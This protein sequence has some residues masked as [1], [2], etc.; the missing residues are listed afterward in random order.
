MASSLVIHIAAGEDKHT[1]VLSQDRIRIGASEDCELRLQASS[2]PA[3]PRADGIL[4]EL[5]RTNGHYRIKDFDQ[6]LDLT[7]NGKPLAVNA[8]IKDGDEVRCEPASLALSFFPV[9][10]LPALIGHRQQTQVA[11]FIETA[12]M[13]SAATAR[14]D[15]AKVFLREFT[16]EL[17][18]EIKP[19]TKIITLAIALALVGGI[20]YLGFGLYNELKRS[21][22]A[23]GGLRE[24]LA[25][26]QKQIADTKKLLGDLDKSNQNIL[27]SLSLAPKLRTDYGGGVCMILGSYDFIEKSTG[28]PLRYPEVQTNEDGTVIQNGDETMQLTPEGNGAIAEFQAV[29]SGFHV[30]DGYVLT[31]RHVAHPWLAD[32]RA[33]ILTSSVRGTPRLK[34]LLA[35]FPDHAQ[36]ITLKFKMAAQRDDLAVCTF[37]PGEAPNNLPALPLDQDSDAV[38]VGKTVVLMGYPN[39]PDRLLALRDD[40]E[41]YLIRARCGGSLGTLLN[42][43]SEKNRIQPLTTQGNITDLDVHRVVYDARTAEG[44]SGAPLFGQSGRVIGVNFAIFTENTASNFAVPI[45]YA[46]TLLER[47]GWKSPDATEEANENTDADSNQTSP[48]SGTATTNSSRQER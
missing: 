30:G 40:A 37:E 36:P 32:E 22:R 48:R 25:E 13:E 12:A 47:A 33:Q 43:L 8:K 14:R 23:D 45:R 21:R 44:G 46:L 4:L 28:R 7:H 16:R 34:K 15:D 31:N 38:A 1:E 41:A 6:S 3:E 19:T 11:P 9:R 42:C 27:G 26:A 17:V 24:Q 39:G 20:L 29:G 10:D 5:A 18:R 2:L 35:Y